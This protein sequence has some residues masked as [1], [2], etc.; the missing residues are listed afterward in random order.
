M[1]TA[2][3]LTIL[4][5]SAQAQ[6]W[7]GAL[8]ELFVNSHLGLTIFLIVALALH[9]WVQFK[10]MILI[11]I[12][13][14]VL[15]WT[16]KLGQWLHLL[17]V[18]GRVTEIQMHSLSYY[19]T[20]VA[21]ASHMSISLPSKIDIHPGQYLYV[22]VSGLSPCS[23]VQSHPFY[24]FWS[25]EEELTSG[26]KLFF[27][28]QKGRG[29]SE[30]LQPHS[31]KRPKQIFLEGPFGKRIDL[32][33]RQMMFFCATGVGIAAVLPFIKYVIE[34]HSTE[35]RKVRVYWVVDKQGELPSTRRGDAS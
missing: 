27:L 12:G 19:D 26:M 9:A 31:G 7:S 2:M 30:L 25:E 10:I 21:E 16:L 32:S 1:Q 23:I 15:S 29:L 3:I 6:R 18:A 34:N 13:T 8:Y 17:L 11:C 33:P 24:V 35:G 14:I 28:I 5:L 4:L 22:R 20:P